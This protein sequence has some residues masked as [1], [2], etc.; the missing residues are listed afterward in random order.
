MKS[1]IKIPDGVKVNIDGFKVI[2]SGPKGETSKV[3]KNAFTTISVVGDE[4]IIESSKNNRRGKAVINTFKAHINNLIN[5]VIN[6][7]E[8]KLKVCVGHFP[9][10]VKVDGDK[11]IVENFF[12]EKTP[13]TLKLRGD[14]EVSVNGDEVI[15]KGINKESVGQTAAD[16]EQLTRITNRDRRLFQDGIWIIKKPGRSAL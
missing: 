10:T 5:G 11:F 2:V 14:C 7:Y 4:V 9:M 3:L 8:A 1:V 6:G 16:I 12:G 15:V 13:R